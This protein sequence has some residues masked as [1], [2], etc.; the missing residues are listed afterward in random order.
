MRAHLTTAIFASVFTVAVT[1]AA[2]AIAGS[3]I[4]GIF[5]IGETNT[6]DANS[7]LTGA[8]NGPQLSVANTSTGT[9][10]AGIKI[11]TPNSKPPLTVTSSQ[12]APNL[13]ADLVDGRTADSLAR[14][15][16]GDDDDSAW[17]E[18]ARVALRSVTLT[19]PAAGFVMLSGGATPSYSTGC[20]FCAVHLRFRVDST[21]DTSTTAATITQTNHTQ[22]VPLSTTATVP[23]TKGT[24]TYE[25]IGSWFDVD[26]MGRQPSVWYDAKLSAQYVP[27][28]GSGGTNPPAKAEAT[29]EQAGPS[30]LSSP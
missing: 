18:D 21:T 9:N 1:I 6:V 28:N 12:K 25:L 5:R 15:A 16:Y 20:P 13:T 14:V 29:A 23:V 3:G 19:A 24:H 4:G 17:N 10:A 26:K 7:T 2:S 22:I 30:P 11:T 27:F 8:T